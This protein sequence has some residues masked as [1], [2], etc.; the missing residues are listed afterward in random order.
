MDSLE[1][2]DFCYAKAITAYELVPHSRPE[3]DGGWTGYAGWGREVHSGYISIKLWGAIQIYMETVKFKIWLVEGFTRWWFQIFFIFIPIWGD[4]PIW[5][6][7][8]R[9]VET[10]NQFRCGL[11]LGICCAEQSLVWGLFDGNDQICKNHVMNFE[12]WYPI[13]SHFPAIISWFPII[14][15]SSHI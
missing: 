12:F 10:A 13:I 14:S 7:F 6:I 2:G 4:D 1:E 15:S 3:E 8:F 11:W 9:W 5:L